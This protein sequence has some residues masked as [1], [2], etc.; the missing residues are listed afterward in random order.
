MGNGGALAQNSDLSLGLVKGLMGMDGRGQA[1]LPQSPNIV[2]H[3]SKTLAKHFVSVWNQVDHT[4]PS[5]E[6][7]THQLTNGAILPH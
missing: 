7:A 6:A 2:Q 1:P 3:E 4:I 5:E